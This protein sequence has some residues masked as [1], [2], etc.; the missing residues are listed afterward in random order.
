[1]ILN[2]PDWIEQL[3]IS[4]NELCN[5]YSVHFRNVLPKDLPDSPGVFLI[6]MIEDHYEIPYWIEWTDSIKKR[7]QGSMLMGGFAEKSF[8]KDLIEKKICKDIDEAKQF[9]R[10][11]CTLRWI[12]L[13]DTVLRN[14]LANYGRAVLMPRCGL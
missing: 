9:I 7:I 13:K 14:A 5:K 11:K 8:K 3:T 4:L 2:Q 10:E 1:M 6:T 12:R